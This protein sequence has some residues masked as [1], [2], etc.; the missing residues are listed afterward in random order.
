MVKI[1]S[2]FNESYAAWFIELKKQQMTFYGNNAHQLY[3]SINECTFRLP[4]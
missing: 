4:Y 2:S 3:K 1:Y